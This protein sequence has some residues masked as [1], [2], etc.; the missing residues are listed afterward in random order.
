MKQD[1][2]YY[3]KV[4]VVGNT[5]HTKSGGGITMSNLFKGWPVNKLAAA[6]YMMSISEADICQI[7]Y[8]LGNKEDIRP[9]IFR[10]FQKRRKSGEIILDDKSLKKYNSVNSKESQLYKSIH[11]LVEKIINFIGLHHYV[12]RLKLSIEFTEWLMKFNPDII[13]AQASN[14]QLVKF[15]NQINDELKIPYVLHIMDNHYNTMIIG[16]ILKPYWKAVLKR[17]YL[18]LLKN[19]KSRLSISEGMSK[20]YQ[21]KFGLDFLPCHN[22]V[23]SD[24]WLK[25]SK[26]N[27]KENTPFTLMYAGRIGIGTEESL[28]DIAEA[29]E[30][31]V[32]EGLDIR[33]KIQLNI[34]S[35]NVPP[36][37]ISLKYTQLHNFISY[38]Q[39]PQVLSR[40]DVLLLPIDFD[41]KAQRYIKYSMPTKVTEFMITGVPILVYAP[42]DTA[43]VNYARVNDWALIVNK[44]NKSELKRAI[45]DLYLNEELRKS[46]GER[47]RS[48]ALLKH[49]SKI[50]CEN[51][52]NTIAMA[53]K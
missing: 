24:S 48:I 7:Y 27:W 52:R 25:Y 5:F 13:Y 2:K 35:F 30:E 32:N 10:L 15:I 4:L 47:G 16:G 17:E 12:Y 26:T 22:P 42:E 31:L 9:F 40:A 34:N 41:E 44:K 38:D 39:L 19:S 43:M 14:L 29:V 36:R 18:K 21:Q 11:N 50:V 49:D 33:L 46:L 23:D 1:K 53:A 8:Q 6:T 28:I 51:F 45:I 3:P 37:L 20:I